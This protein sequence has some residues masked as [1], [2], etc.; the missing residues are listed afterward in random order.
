MSAHPAPPAGPGFEVD[1]LVP[2]ADAA[3]REWSRRLSDTWQRSWRLVALIFLLTFAAPN[4]AAAVIAEAT[5]GAVPV[6]GGWPVSAPGGLTGLSPAMIGATLLVSMAALFVSAIGWGAGVWAVTQAA[7]GLPATVVEALQAGLRR[8]WPMFGTYLLYVLLILVGALVFLLPGLY[9]AFAGALFSFAVIYE[10]GRSALVR[11]FVLVHKGFVLALGRVM[12][13]ALGA[14]VAGAAGT[15]FGY[16]LGFLPTED[17]VGNPVAM[18]VVDS[19]IMVPVNVALLTGLLL[20]YTQ[21]RAREEQ[22][23]TGQLWAA[24]NSQ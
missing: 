14:I 15:A 2:P 17:S 9:V 18:A 10:R 21:L 20:I 1:P 3:L 12:V 8:V 6:T 22:L 4:I 23:T 24:A 11:S 13:L 5:F 16:G 7:A 19:L